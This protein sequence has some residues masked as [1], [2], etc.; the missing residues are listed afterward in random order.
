MKLWA[1]R[2]MLLIS[3]TLLVLGLGE[4]IARRISTSRNA[5]FANVLA[6]KRGVERSGLPAINGL[7]ELA[8]PDQHGVHRGV[9]YTTNSRGLRA[10]EVARCPD[11]ETFRIAVGGDSIAVGWGVEEE[12]RYSSRLEQLLEAEPIGSWERHE[13]LNM[14]L[15]GLNAKLGVRRLLH[16]ASHYRADLIVFG[17]TPNDE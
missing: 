2:M 4:L 9:T 17:F 6:K 7:I 14:A 3:S 12:L 5:E 8:R 13:V 10:P 1:L 15:A 16:H 11:P